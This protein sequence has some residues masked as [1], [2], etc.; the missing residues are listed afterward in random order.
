MCANF[1]HLLIQEP[2]LNSLNT[3]D[4]NKSFDDFV[5]GIKL[6]SNGEV[7]WNISDIDTSQFKC[8]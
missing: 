4:F 7:N 8:K 1:T 6:A 5:K 3:I 2:T